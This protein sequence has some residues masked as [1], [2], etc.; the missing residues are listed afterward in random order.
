MTPSAESGRTPPSAST[1]TTP[2]SPCS[3]LR[4]ATVASSSSSTST[5]TRSRPIRP[6][7]TRSGCTAS[8]SRWTTSTKPSRSRPRHGCRPLRGVATYGEVYKLTYLQRSERHHRDAGPGAEPADTRVGKGV[9]LTVPARRVGRPARTRCAEGPGRS[10]CPQVARLGRSGRLGER[11][12]DEAWLIVS[13]R[14]PRLPRVRVSAITRAPQLRRAV[15]DGNG[16]Q[17]SATQVLT[18][19]PRP[20][21]R[22]VPSLAMDHR[23]E[24]RRP[25]RPAP[26]RGRSKTPGPVAAAPTAVS[27]SSPAGRLPPPRP[28]R[29]SITAPEHPDSLTAHPVTH[30]P[31][32]T[33]H[34]P[35]TTHKGFDA[36]PPGSSPA[37]PPASAARS[38]R[39]SSQRGDNVVVTAREPRVAD[40]ADVHPD[41]ALA[42]ALDVTDPSRSRGGAAAEA[43][44][45]AS[46]CWSTTPATATGPPSRRVTS[47]RAAPFATTSSGRAMT[48]AVLPGMRARRS[49]PILNSPRSAPASA[50]RVGLLRCHEGGAR[51][52]SGSLRKEVEPLGIKVD[53]VEPGGSAPIS[54][55]G[56]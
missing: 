21:Q 54:P 17:A 14:A 47:R 28:R 30:S 12:E 1:E 49:G 9:A 51:R 26:S 50:R 43:A 41:N 44:F 23:R 5:R 3:R 52:L 36:C 31:L 8:R 38:P 42:L 15:L 27:A 22:P 39:P 11:G 13:A 56:R 29:Q 40:L 18:G 53:V 7:P 19:P 46:T 2:G 45:G 4:T 20:Q 48:K 24:I 32:T 6:D 55:A 34:S 35:L 33:H 16:R 37:A 10:P 25:S